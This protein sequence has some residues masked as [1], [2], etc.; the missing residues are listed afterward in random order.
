[1]FVK[2]RIKGQRKVMQS[3]CFVGYYRSRRTIVS[4]L[5]DKRRLGSIENEGRIKITY[6]L[7]ATYWPRY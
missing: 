3:R 5:W 2:I 7:L 6:S 1:M 4:S